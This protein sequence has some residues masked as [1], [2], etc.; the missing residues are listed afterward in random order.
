MVATVTSTMVCSCFF[1]AQNKNVK[2]VSYQETT[3]ENQPSI[4]AIDEEIL[5]QEQEL[6]ENHRY[7]SIKEITPREKELIAR[8][9]YHESRGEDEIGQIAVCEIVLN[10]IL[11][12]VYPNTVEEVLFQYNGKFYQFSCA[13]YLMTNDIREPE[14][15]DKALHIV[16][17]VLS[18]GYSPVLPLDY[19][20]FSTGKPRTT[21]YTQIGNHYF[22]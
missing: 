5:R 8:C 10:R 4:A 18:T 3:Q 1:S 21:N 14:A 15:L 11:S 2:V 20:Y 13:P 17:Y 19:L 22:W 7:V 12:D 6:W 16:D 9:I